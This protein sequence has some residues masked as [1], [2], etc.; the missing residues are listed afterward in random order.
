M[1][2]CKK[3]GAEMTDES[4]FCKKCGAKFE[5][6]TQAETQ[7]EKQTDNISHDV[8]QSNRNSKGLLIALAVICV[9]L[10]GFA[11]YEY[12]QV[13]SSKAYS[14][15]LEEQV[16][17]LE[18]EENGLRNRIDYLESQNNHLTDEN[19]IPSNEAEAAIKQLEGYQ[20]G[21]ETFASKDWQGW[22][23]YNLYSFQSVITLKEKMT[24]WL[25]IWHND[26]IAP[27][28][29]W[30]ETVPIG[31]DKDDKVEIQFID[32]SES[33]METLAITGKNKGMTLLRVYTEDTEDEFYVLVVVE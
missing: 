2:Y 15:Q 16:A 32:D 11:I 13:Q 22:G 3:C 8:S 6:S 24:N 4:M 17:N 1:K 7:K 29:I 9:C 30:V 5:K 23:G 20:K 33:M 27:D 10:A 21:L 31:N 14:N 12:T 18:A 25:C 28:K 19:T 26:T